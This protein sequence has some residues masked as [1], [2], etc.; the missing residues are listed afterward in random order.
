MKAVELFVTCLENEGV[1]YVHANGKATGSPD[2][3]VRVHPNESRRSRDG[4]NPPGRCYRGG[5]HDR[6]PSDIVDV[7]GVLGVRRSPVR[8]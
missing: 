2:G 3:H 7:S 4:P 6:V 5:G 8:R 1:N